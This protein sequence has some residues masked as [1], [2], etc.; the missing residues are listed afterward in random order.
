[1]ITILIQKD[2]PSPLLLGTDVLSS[3]GFYCTLQKPGKATNILGEICSSNGNSKDAETQITETQTTETQNAEGFKGESS[4]QQPDVLS[5][6]KNQ[7]TRELQLAQAIHIPSRCGKMVKGV[8]TTVEPESL[9]TLLFTPTSLPEGLVMT[10]TVLSYE[11]NQYVC[12]V[13]E[14]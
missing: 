8:I 11:G 9:D 3:L 6:T 2:A 12:T 1:M 5:D 4:N 14:N 13:V 7:S 10:D